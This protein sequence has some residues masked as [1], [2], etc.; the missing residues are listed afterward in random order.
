MCSIN[1]TPTTVDA[2]MESFGLGANANGGTIVGGVSK[3]IIL[4]L[5]LVRIVLFYRIQ[6]STWFYSLNLNLQSGL[7]NCGM[8]GGALCGNAMANVCSY[9]QIPNSNAN[10]VL[11]ASCSNDLYCGKY[12]NVENG[13]AVDGVITCE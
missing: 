13:A 3:Y 1:Y 8:N 2:T 7:A 10:C 11:A 12:L 4:V 9:V 6:F 5:Y